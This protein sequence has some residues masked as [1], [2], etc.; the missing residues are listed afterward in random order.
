MTR[1]L[2]HSEQRSGKSSAQGPRGRSTKT[3]RVKGQWGALTVRKQSTEYQERS[4]SQGQPWERRT[5]SG[6]GGGVLE[7]REEVAT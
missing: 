3:K 1:E 4:A 5:G 6:G 2:G 7:Q